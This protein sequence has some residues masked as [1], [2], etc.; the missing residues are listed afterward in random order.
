LLN[1]EDHKPG[2][3]DP[4]YKGHLNPPIVPQELNTTPP[5][6]ILV[7]NCYF[8]LDVQNGLSFIANKKWK[9]ILKDEFPA[10]NETTTIK[11]TKKDLDT[12]FFLL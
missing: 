6:L 1:E 3:S 11:N 5:L 8:K 2:K 10:Y 12:K 7:R 9:Q 4:E